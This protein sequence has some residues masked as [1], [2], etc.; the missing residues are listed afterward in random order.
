MRARGGTRAFPAACAR[1]TVALMAK[2]P[3]TSAQR[4]ARERNLRSGNPKAY[5][6]PAQGGS[7]GAPGEKPAV[8]PRERPGSA[9][10]NPGPGSAQGGS[11]GAP[12]ENKTFR[13]AAP[14]G[15]AQ[16]APRTKQAKPSRAAQGAVQGA[17]REPDPVPA[18]AG[19][20]KTGFL[21]DVFGSVF[22]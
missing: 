18:P 20:P 13:G 1:P 21:D 16:G 11:Q 9:Q 15:A 5:S 4:A 17:P 6:K 7:Q 10:G 14:Q 8:S 19:E 3:E 12:R 22:G 2:T